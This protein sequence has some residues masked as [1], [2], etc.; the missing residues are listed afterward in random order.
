[1]S[2]TIAVPS[3]IA[4]LLR[5]ALIN[6]LGSAAADVA[7]LTETSIHE[8]SP[9]C[10]TEP[11]RRLDAHRALLE[12]I[13]FG[14][15][16]QQSPIEVDID[17]HLW[18]LRASLQAE[19]SIEREFAEVEPELEG[20]ARQRERAERAARDIERFLA[21][22]PDLPDLAGGQDVAQDPGA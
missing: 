10:F 1:M 9:D 22:L 8:Q 19:L 12:A 15:E 20:A 2:R 13:G 5:P 16:Q 17:T 14:Y 6:E 4:E 18:S 21:G 11:L 3:P 7:G